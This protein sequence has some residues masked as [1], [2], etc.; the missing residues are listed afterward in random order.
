MSIFNFVTQDELDDLDEDPRMAF[1]GLF[2]HAQRNLSKQLDRLDPND[3][4]EWKTRQ[5]IEQSFMNVIVAAGK[6]Y[7]IEPFVSTQVPQYADYRTSDYQ[8]FR[9]DLDH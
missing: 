6:R 5:D 9:Y 1:L 7:E 3:E 8:Q 2:N 4:R